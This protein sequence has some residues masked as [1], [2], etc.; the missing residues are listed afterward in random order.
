MR[1]SQVRFLSAPPFKSSHGSNRA[2][3]WLV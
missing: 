2:R 3:L 1:R